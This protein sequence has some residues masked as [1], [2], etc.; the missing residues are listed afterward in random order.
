MKNNFSIAESVGCTGFGSLI[1]IS[2]FCCVESVIIEAS[3]SATNYWQLSKKKSKR[4]PSAIPRPAP[5]RP[6]SWLRF[7]RPGRPPKRTMAPTCRL[8]PLGETREVASP[9]PP[10]DLLLAFEDGWLTRLRG[11]LPRWPAKRCRALFCQQHRGVPETHR[12]HRFV[13]KRRAA[14]RA[15][16]DMAR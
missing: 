1:A 5:R 10:G 14:P 15:P 3:D 8:G 16:Q 4:W 12:T 7:G 6:H 11:K 13:Y 2:P 9:S